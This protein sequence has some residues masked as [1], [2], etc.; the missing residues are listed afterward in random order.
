MKRTLLIICILGW[1][2]TG[3]AQD[4]DVDSLFTSYLGSKGQQRQNSAA[5]LIE[6]L[7]A[8]EYTLRQVD[9]N[10][11]ERYVE[12]ILL[13]AMSSYKYEHGE[14][15]LCIDYAKKSMADMNPDSIAWQYENYLLMDIAS[16][17]KGDYET[18]LECAQKELPI[19]EQLGDDYMAC[20][21]L[22]NLTGIYLS[23]NQ[24]A[25]A[26][27]YI[28]RAIRLVRT[29]GSPYRLATYLGS[30]CEVLSR[31]ER[32]E[33]ALDC[34]NEALEIEREGGRQ[35]RIAVRLSQKAGALMKL[36]QFD[37]AKQVCEEACPV[38]ESVGN[39]PSLAITLRQLADI[40]FT[41]G[42]YQDAQKYGQQCLDVCAAHGLDK[43]QSDVYH[44]LYLNNKE[45]HPK[46]ALEYYEK[47]VALHDELITTEH[48]RLLTEF[49]VKYDLQQKDYELQIERNENQRKS[50]LLLYLSVLALLLITLAIVLWRT[51]VMRR[52]TNIELEQLNKSTNHM[53][54]LLS[55][56][57]KNAVL[58]Q[59]RMLDEVV[60]HIE[61]F[62]R[63]DIVMS[64]Q[65]FRDSATNNTNMLTNILQW[66]SFETGRVQY[67]PV[68]VN[69][70]RIV[71]EVFEQI[72]MQASQKQV[73]LVNGIGE[74]EF[75][76]TDAN[77][78]KSVLNNLINNAVKFTK[79]DGSVTVGM[80]LHDEK[81]YLTV[82][83]TGVGMTEEQKS[84]LLQFK[85]ASAPGTSGEMGTGIGLYICKEL[86]NNFG[87]TID[88]ESEVGKGTKFTFSI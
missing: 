55:H 79:A 39:Y 73:Q 8:E 45:S 81:T 22:N 2:L 35:A 59:K 9:N 42:N 16:Q 52:K 26:E 17:R 57:M 27:Q 13:N 44:L 23:M 83:D 64:L 84:K 60:D 48:Q 20:A 4:F 19:A 50:S 18:A 88:V 12:R 37:E 24:P 69:L 74:N 46:L 36:E 29:Q 1:V 32:Y 75:A 85:K 58:G 68:R 51:S 77:I 80:E 49:Q 41:Q 62:S 78:I 6:Y 53:F 70:H 72:G 33:E 86:L 87:A 65:M 82:T 30:K 61:I 63:D 76:V 40:A 71:S 15:D 10:M 28:D 11:D 38:F 47:Y 56:D 67:T 31:Q 21:T 5:L 34:I 3:F 66:V 7:D 43:F 54:S 25:E 14:Y